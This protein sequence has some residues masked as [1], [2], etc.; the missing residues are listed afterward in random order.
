MFFVAVV[1]VFFCFCFCRLMK[2]YTVRSPS[3]WKS[4]SIAV[5]KT[6]GFSVKPKILFLLFTSAFTNAV[7]TV[8]T[9]FI[10]FWGIPINLRPTENLNLFGI[11]C[12]VNISL[13]NAKA[14]A[15]TEGFPSNFHSYTGTFAEWHLCR[16]FQCRYKITET[17]AKALFF[18]PSVPHAP[19]L[20]D[21][22]GF[23]S[24]PSLPLGF[25]TVAW[26]LS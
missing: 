8:K 11:F 26:L 18:F 10:I 14:L 4:L 7:K 19:S 17:C 24:Q 15:R 5:K 22:E 25:Q 21:R 13:L 20:P 23:F 1:L 9:V 16:L 6:K 12:V 3:E 2:R